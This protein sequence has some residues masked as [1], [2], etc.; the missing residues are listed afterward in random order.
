MI[1]NIILDE[2]NLIHFNSVFVIFG[3]CAVVWAVITQLKAHSDDAFG[4]GSSFLATPT[5]M[6]HHIVIGTIQGLSMFAIYVICS[7]PYLSLRM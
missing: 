3:Y 5:G 4:V 7:R 6:T 1:N 2:S